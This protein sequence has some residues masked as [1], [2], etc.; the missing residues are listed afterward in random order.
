MRRFVNDD[1]GYVAWLA[2]HPGGYVLNTYPDVTSSYLVLH[3]ASCRTV[4]RALAVGRNWTR[5]YG[6]SCADD[7]SELE[8]WALR[9]AGK[10][11]EGCG[12]CLPSGASGPPSSPRS[13]TVVGTHGPRAPRLAARD[14]RFEGQPIR[15]AVSGAGAS[16][17]AAPPFVIEGAQAD[18]LPANWIAFYFI[19]R[20]EVGGRK[21]VRVWGRRLGSV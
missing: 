20:S 9:E 19:C 21:A 17:R 16:G 15:I 14:V 6:K 12:N 7:R 10:A 8:A 2:S 5:L 3:R 13:A 11:V 4:N 18:E 1:A